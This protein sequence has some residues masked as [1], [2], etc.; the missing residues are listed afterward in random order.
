MV[1]AEHRLMDPGCLLEVRRRRRVE[2][3][4]QPRRR[5]GCGGTDILKCPRQQL[6]HPYGFS[7]AFESYCVKANQKLTCLAY[8]RGRDRNRDSYA[9]A[10]LKAFRSICGRAAAPAPRLV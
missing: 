4:A 5:N 8:F 9:F 2:R 10:S 7:Q 1:L 6:R 3:A